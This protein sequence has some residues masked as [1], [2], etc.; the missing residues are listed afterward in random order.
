MV[1]KNCKAK[2]Y[3]IWDQTIIGTYNEKICKKTMLKTCDLQELYQNGMKYKRATA[4]EKRI[5]G[6]AINKMRSYS[7][8]SIKRNNSSKKNNHKKG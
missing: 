6:A 7:Q 5:S 3:A 2:E 8:C 1:K 4:R